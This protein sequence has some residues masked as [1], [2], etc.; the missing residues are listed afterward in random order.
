VEGKKVPAS[1]GKR[2]GA[3][4]FYSG[5]GKRKRGYPPNFREG[6]KK[7]KKRGTRA[8]SAQRELFLTVSD[9]RR[10]R[11]KKKRL[12]YLLLSH[13]LRGEGEACKRA[14][15][16]I[17]AGGGK[18]G[19]NLH[20]PKKRRGKGFALRDPRFW[21]CGHS[22]EIIFFPYGEGG[23]ETIP[24]FPDLESA[25]KRGEEGLVFL[26]YFGGGRGRGRP[27][28]LRDAFSSRKKGKGERPFS[29]ST[30]QRGKEKK[31]RSNDYVI[32]RRPFFVYMEGEKASSALGEEML[33]FCS[34]RG[35]GATSR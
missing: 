9:R 27:F 5:G 21:R 15:R 24:P 26:Y 10:E 29:H 8:G 2:I 30:H 19:L 33:L 11:E 1:S 28:A 12:S 16:P 22:G 35:R 4:P 6:E 3:D 17:L 18:E 25:R 14:R 7:K 23:D 20:P 13:Q 32:Y 31:R 34:K